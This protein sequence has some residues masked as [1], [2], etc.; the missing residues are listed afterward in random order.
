MI[1][2]GTDLVDDRLESW[3]FP[4]IAFTPTPVKPHRLRHFNQE[5]LARRA[6][7]QICQVDVV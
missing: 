4:A 2:A 3:I 7:T 6:K 1:S 5:R